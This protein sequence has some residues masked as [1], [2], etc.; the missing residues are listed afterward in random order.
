M[1]AEAHHSLQDLFG[2][3]I[4]AEIEAQEMYTKIS[5]HTKNFVLKEKMRFLASEEKKHERI[6]RGLFKQRFAGAEP[7]IPGETV[8]PVPGWRPEE[9]GKVSDVLKA[10]MQTELDA[11]VFYEAMAERITEPKAE[12]ILK[13]LAAMEQTHYHMLET[14]HNAAMEIEDYDR[15][16][17]AVHW[18][19]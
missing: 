2:I 4:K 6:L 12:S 19:A 17:P 18:G 11:K 15:F 8:A 13:Y 1:K 3:A 16:D 5:T 9:E 14:E 7:V 10:A